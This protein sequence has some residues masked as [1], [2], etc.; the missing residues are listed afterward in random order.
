M[1]EAINI[2]D[3]LPVKAASEITTEHRLYL[4][5][6]RRMRPMPKLMTSGRCCVGTAG[7]RGG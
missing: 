1:A 6:Q 4:G 7:F 2:L 3:A 5:K